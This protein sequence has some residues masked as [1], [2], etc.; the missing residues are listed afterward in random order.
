MSQFNQATDFA[1]GR[2]LVDGE[3]I[4]TMFFSAELYENI[5]IQAVTGTI[6]VVDTSSNQLL[7]KRRLEGNEEIEFMAETPKGNVEFKGY[8]N[9]IA[10]GL[11]VDP[12]DW[13]TPSR[14]VWLQRKG[15]DWLSG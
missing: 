3:D 13:M 15:R 2:L 10:D 14:E 9:R 5:Y 8:I 12:E 1:V 11:G 6:I 4:R 7:A